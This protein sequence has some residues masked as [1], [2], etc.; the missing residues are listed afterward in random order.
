MTRPDRPD[1]PGDVHDEDHLRWLLATAAD[2]TPVGPPPVA[3]MLRHHRVRRRSRLL[4]AAAVV[5]AG[6][7]VGLATSV[8]FDREAD[9]DPAT[10]ASEDAGRLADPVQ[11]ALGPEPAAASDRQNAA[12]DS[13]GE[14]DESV[15]YAWT[16]IDGVPPT[17]LLDGTWSVV[18]AEPAATSF[19]GGTEYDAVL[20][21]RDAVGA[22]LSAGPATATLYFADGGAVTAWTG[23]EAGAGTWALEDGTVRIELSRGVPLCDD[24]SDLLAALAGD[25]RSVRGVGAGDGTRTLLDEDGRVLAVLR[26]P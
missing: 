4:V 18:P 12:A 22:R 16:S 23:C 13:A 20:E 17:D 24:G 26:R 3:A 19:L 15:P 9:R 10:A 6:A 11:E 21:D 25:L 2:P 1:L 14:P 5:V 8:P 7:G